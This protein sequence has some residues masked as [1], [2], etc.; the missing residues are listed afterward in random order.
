MLYPVPPADGGEADLAE[1]GDPLPQA[2]SSHADTAE[3]SQSAGAVAAAMPSAA[4][5]PPAAE[6]AG[7]VHC[8]AGSQLTC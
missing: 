4:N 3:I 6:R 2:V 8:H 7:A 1:A 5:A